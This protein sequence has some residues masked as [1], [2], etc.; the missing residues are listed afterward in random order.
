MSLIQDLKGEGIRAI[1]VKP[2]MDKIMR[3]NGHLARIEAGCVQLPR[4]ASWLD[5]FRKELM[6]FLL[7]NMTIKSTRSPKPWTE[8]L[9]NVGS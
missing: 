1:P 7:A 2:I 8:R 4:L 3:M 6:E 5:D 9:S